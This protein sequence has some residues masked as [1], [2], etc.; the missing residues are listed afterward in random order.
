MKNCIGCKYA[1]WEF[2][3]A[4]RLH[5]SGDGRCGW[6]FKPQKL[7]AAFYWINAPYPAGG[8]INRRKEL[9]EHCVYYEHEKAK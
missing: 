9:K 2:T 1:E 7:P 4:G 3:K 8:C 5:P 6:E